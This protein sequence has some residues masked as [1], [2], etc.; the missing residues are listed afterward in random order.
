MFSSIA[1]YNN[2]E[3]ESTFKDIFFGKFDLDK[4]FM[5]INQSYY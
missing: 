2:K 1:I 3:L 5:L 4:D